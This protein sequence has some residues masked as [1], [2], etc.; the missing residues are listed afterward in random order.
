ML[1]FM[2]GRETPRKVPPMTATQ[3]AISILT[4]LRDDI[5]TLNAGLDAVIAIMRNG[6]EVDRAAVI[7]EV[8]RRQ[9]HIPV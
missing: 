7:A 2:A 8:H 4:L 9:P 6:A 3:T 1:L 5:E